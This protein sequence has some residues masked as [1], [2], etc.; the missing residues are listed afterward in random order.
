MGQCCVQERPNQY[1]FKDIKLEKLKNSSTEIS[2]LRRSAT[3]NL[4]SSLVKVKTIIKNPF[5]NCEKTL[6]II[7][8]KNV[9]KTQSSNSLLHFLKISSQNSSKNCSFIYSRNE[10]KK[11]QD[12]EEKN[13]VIEEKDD[14]EEEEC[15]DDNNDI[16]GTDNIK[17]PLKDK[18]I[19]PEEQSKI[20]QILVSNFLF[21]GLN[22]EIVHYVMS[23]LIQLQIENGKFIY[24]K[25][26]DKDFFYIIAKGKVNLIS[27]NNKIVKTYHQ[28]ES[29]GHMSLFCNMMNQKMKYSAQCEGDVILYVLDGE[30][31]QN[32]QKELNKIRLK[33]QFEFLKKIP[34]FDALHN[35]EKYNIVEKIKI[36]EY[37]TGD[38]IVHED[39]TDNETMYLI[40]SGA[41]K[42]EKNKNS[43][44]ILGENEYFGLENI[45]LHRSQNNNFN[46]NVIA[47][48]STICYQISKKDL[49][50]AFGIE[51]RDI[52]LFSIFKCFILN[53]TFFKD[54]FSEKH[55]ES[56]FH[57]FHLFFYKNEQNLYSPTKN[58]KRIVMVIEGNVINK[59]TKEIVATR[60]NIIGKDII[61]KNLDLPKNLIAYPILFSLESDLSNFKKIFNFNKTF[62]KSLTLMKTSNK[63]KKIP[64]FKFLSDNVLNSLANTMI[65]QKYTD[66]QMI[67]QQGKQGNTFFLIKKGSVKIIKNNIFIREIGEGS[68]FGEMAL[69]EDENNTN[70]IR[71][72]SVVAVGNVSCFILSKENFETILQNKLIKQYITEKIAIQNTDIQ[73]TDLYYVKSLGRGRFGNVILVKNDKNFYGLKSVPIKRVVKDRMT[74]YLISERNIMM[75]IDHPFI[76]KLVKTLKD[77]NF[78]YFLLEYINGQSLA[79]YLSRRCLYKQVNEVQFYSAIMLIIVDYLQKK[80]IIHR[81]IKPGNIMIDKNGYLKLIDFGTSKVVQDYT[82]T[83]LGTPEYIAPEILKGKGYSLSCDFW[84]VGILAYEIFYGKCPFGS[85][86]GN[87]ILSIYKSI[88]YDEVK[89]S[90]SPSTQKVDEFLKC[91]LVKKVN[92]RNCSLNTLRK[93]KLF[94]LENVEGAKRPLK[95]NKKSELSPSTENDNCFINEKDYLDMVM[96]DEIKPPYLPLIKERKISTADNEDKLQFVKYGRQIMI[97]EISTIT[98]SNEKESVDIIESKW[99]KEF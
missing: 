54:I 37:N 4:Q 99:F 44:K 41:I 42:I 7:S 53:H 40:K 77:D 74:Q 35:I 76:I 63:L 78:C 13:E 61:M 80:S 36:H 34:I 38:Y 10:T 84:S 16:E 14:E 97:D 86:C 31:F 49:I 19:T 81:D 51:Y 25:G 45:L 22:D 71:T 62:K 58:N 8:Q 67:I 96:D 79:E 17:I 23:E 26:F 69:F 11:R 27:K 30:N 83:V 88:L 32:V 48:G 75:L 20:Y 46:V 52:I 82:S 29:F 47:L 90:N 93:L 59:D 91:L 98:S 73:L 89:Y 72:A 57:S 92:K 85:N 66:N 55:I 18:E 9:G 95:P 12:M 39:S 68:C 1:S 87:D 33:E 56:I 28:W 60:G 21:E 5:S 24:E 70:K 50:E 64:I 94:S 2:K 3:E 6:K 43:L 65:K 15:D